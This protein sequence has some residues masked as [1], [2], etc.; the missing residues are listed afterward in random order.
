MFFSTI[1]LIISCS[2]NKNNET[3]ED[4]NYYKLNK[5]KRVEKYQ[6]DF[7]FGVVDST[8]KELEMVYEYDT[9]GNEIKSIYYS[10]NYSVTFDN[11]DEMKMDS[12]VTIKTYDKKGNEISTIGYDEVGKIYF[13]TTST[14]N[15]FNRVVDYVRYDEN[16]ALEDKMHNIFD[17]KG[18]LVSS[19][20]NDFKNK[21]VKITTVLEMEGDIEKE[22]NETDD[23]S[24]LIQ[25]YVLKL[26]NDS[27]SIYD[28]YDSLNILSSRTEMIWYKKIIV[29][30]KNI[31]LRT[32]STNYE[33]RKKLNEMNL[34]KEETSYTDGEPSEFYKYV[35]YKF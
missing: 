32:N 29:G 12:M 14:Y 22:V 5:I 24:N 25:R 21:S 10:K 31:N 26:H 17:N 15:E 13:K 20:S 35:Y 3:K 9:L 27:I 23:K 7:K 6:Y 2:N 4:I 34:P 8:T 18:N 16:G 11:S 1:I 30:S 28:N 19:T 33:Y